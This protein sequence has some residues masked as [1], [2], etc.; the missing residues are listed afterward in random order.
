MLCDWSRKLVPNQFIRVCYSG[1]R[2]DCA[3]FTHSRGLT[4]TQLFATQ[5]AVEVQEEYTFGWEVGTSFLDQSQ[6]VVKQN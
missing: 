4:L 1:P 5:F 6:S 3:T 2:S